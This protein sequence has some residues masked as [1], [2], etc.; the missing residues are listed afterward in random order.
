[1]S[2][3]CSHPDSEPDPD[4]APELDPDTSVRPLLES[5]RASRLLLVVELLLSVATFGLSLAV[6]LGWL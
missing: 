3:D 5:H 6:A 4:S 2:C 1:M